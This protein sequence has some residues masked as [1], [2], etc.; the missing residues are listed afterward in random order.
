MDCTPIKY[1]I[2]SYS[3]ENISRASNVDDLV[4]NDI[5]SNTSAESIKFP[6]SQLNDS[7]GNPLYWKL[8]AFSAN[9]TN[10]ADIARTR[11]LYSLE[12]FSG[13]LRKSGMLTCPF[14]LFIMISTQN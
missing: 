6:T 13:M 7:M 1:Q 4:P 9:G 5:F 2:A 10:C 12:P 8:F 14:T 11:I 3:L